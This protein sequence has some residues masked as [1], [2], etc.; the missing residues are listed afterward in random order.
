MLEAAG[1]LVVEVRQAAVTLIASPAEE[2]VVPSPMRAIM[3]LLL[4]VLYMSV[5]VLQVV[6]VQ[7][8]QLLLRLALRPLP[9]PR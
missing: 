4:A 3:A 1:C 9:P 5:E 7:Q 2:G 6:W 8:G